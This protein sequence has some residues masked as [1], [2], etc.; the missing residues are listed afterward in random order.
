MLGQFLRDNPGITVH[1][2][3]GG[4]DALTENL[5]ADRAVGG[6]AAAIFAGAGQSCA[7]GSRLL[8][9]RTAYDQVVTRLAELADRIRIGHP[10]EE[11]TQVGPLQNRPQ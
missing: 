7:A 9:Q 2:R 10:L 1:V 6:A 3:T 11:G 5:R 4:T 8:V